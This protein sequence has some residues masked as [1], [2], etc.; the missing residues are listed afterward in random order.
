MLYRDLTERFGIKNPSLLKYLLKYVVNNAALP[1]SVTKVFND[2]KSQGYS[3][4]RSTV[5]DYLS[6]LEEAFL[7]FTVDIWHRSVRVQAHNPSK[8]YLIDS[9]F[10]SVMSINEDS[11][12]MLENAVFLHL[13]RQGLLPHYLVANKQE[14]D[15]FWENGVPVNACLDFYEP[16]TKEREVKGMLAAL[17]FLDLPEGLILTRDRAEIIEEKDKTIRVMPA[18]R[19]FLDAS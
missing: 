9:A 7:I 19:Y 17:E 3:V 4:G 6:Y 18:W 14:I 11:G 10:K 8:I 15:F 13:R 2:L 1:L 5:N 12:R 16:T